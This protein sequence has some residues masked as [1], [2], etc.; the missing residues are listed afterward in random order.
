MQDSGS[1]P[2]SG[3]FGPAWISPIL[4][5]SEYVDEIYPTFNKC[6]LEECVQ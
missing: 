6:K 5:F 3:Y 2:T 4:A 1:A